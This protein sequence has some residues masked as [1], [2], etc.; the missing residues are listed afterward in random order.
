MTPR[1]LLCGLTMT[2]SMLLCGCGGNTKTGSS[3]TTSGDPGGATFSVSRA[4]LSFAGSELGA[5]PNS[6]S[7][8]LSYDGTAPLAWR[9]ESTAPWLTAFPDS[10]TLAGADDT[11]TISVS[12]KDLAAQGSAYSATL[13][14][15][16]EDATFA[17]LNIAPSPRAVKH[18]I[19]AAISCVRSM[20]IPLRNKS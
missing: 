6:Q 16:A 7:I 15:V 2:S 8:A 17:P 20:C 14:I 10:G 18:T 11:L 4:A 19:V 1:T 9:V 13:S 5:R 12:T 3:S